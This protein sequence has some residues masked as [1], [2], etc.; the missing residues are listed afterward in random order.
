MTIE[1]EPNYGYKPAAPFWLVIQ[2][3][4]T[5]C[6]GR[7]LCPEDAEDFAAS[8]ASASIN[9][10]FHVLAVVATIEATAKVHGTRFDPH[11]RPPLP[12]VAAPE[13]PE[14]ECFPEAAADIE[15]PF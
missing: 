9:K 3:E 15:D 1:F 12:Q 8:L 4:T 11:K 13:P 5:P 2:G 10:T 7:F 6:G 14:P